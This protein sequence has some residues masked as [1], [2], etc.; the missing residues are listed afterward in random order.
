MKKIIEFL[1]LYFNPCGLYIWIW[2]FYNLQGILY[3]RGSVLSYSLLFVALIISL[4]NL[5]KYF[6][7]PTSDK[8]LKILLYLLIFLTIYGI[9]NLLVTDRLLIGGLPY[10]KIDYL[11]DIFISIIP[12]FSFFVYA[13]KGLL[14]PRLIKA[15]FILFLSVAI[16][17]FYDYRMN[18]ISELLIMGG[19]ETAEI[20]NNTGY[21][22]ISLIPMLAFFKRTLLKY[23]FLFVIL[24]F[25]LICIK[26]GAILIGAISSFY[27]ITKT[28]TISNHKTKIGV[29]IATIILGC[30]CIFYFDQFIENSD[31]FTAR[32]ENTLSGDT[33]G[34]SD[35]ARNFTRHYIDDYNVFYKLI[36][37]GADSTLKYAG[38]Y[39]HRSIVLCCVLDPFFRKF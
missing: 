23:I 5:Y 4:F 20:T 12:I 8:Q 21:V 34:R 7:M 29:I 28:L 18:I 24:F 31:Y 6:R 19:S 10:S 1:G 9:I 38:L 11:K 35:L 14:T 32:L 37:K 36:G 17:K 15:F 13:K 27:L 25:T 2:L 22:F 30:V 16:L 39:A 33:N 3:P 26:R